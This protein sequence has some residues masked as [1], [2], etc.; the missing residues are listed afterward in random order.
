VAWLSAAHDQSVCW[1]GFLVYLAADGTFVNGSMEQMRELQ[2]LLVPLGGIP[3]RQAPG[4][5]PLRLPGAAAAL[6]RL[7]GPQ[8]RARPPAVS[9]TAGSATCLPTGKDLT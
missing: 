6:A 1:I 8:G 5:G 2:Q 4:D 9:K 7:P 3:F